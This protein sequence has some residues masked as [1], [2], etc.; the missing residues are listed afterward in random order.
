MTIAAWF[1]PCGY[2]CVV[3]NADDNENANDM[4]QET[5]KIQV[6]NDTKLCVL[7]VLPDMKT[8]V[9][10]ESI[11][12]LTVSWGIHGHET[13][14][15]ATTIENGYIVLTISASM[16][17][18]VYSVHMQGTVNGDQWSDHRYEMFELVKYGEGI[19]YD[20]YYTTTVILG[21]SDDT[22]YQLRQE[23]EQK[24]AEAEAAKEAWMSKAQALDGL[25]KQGDNPEATN[26]AI[27]NLVMQG[28]GGG[29]GAIPP[30]QFDALAKEVTARKI[31]DAVSLKAKQAD[32]DWQNVKPITE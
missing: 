17:L 30:I 28:G 16:P 23:M 5:I 22:L 26:T 21:L 27:Y 19:R 11:S 18:G 20:R 24:I 31:L 9:P 1:T 3:Y 15:V 25:A 4:K 29:G 6:L 2:L 32:E 8:V 12:G 7:P 13:E 14:P 10:V